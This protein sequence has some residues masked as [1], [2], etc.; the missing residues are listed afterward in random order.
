VAAIEPTPPF[1]Y[2]H[3][4]M[5]ALTDGDDRKAKT[6]FEREVACA[7]DNDEFH[8]WLAIACLRL[9]EKTE[10]RQQL[11]L[12]L[13]TSTTEERRGL[14]SSKLAQLMSARALLNQAPA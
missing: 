2:F 14:Y 10:A 12:A 5:A 7:P 9:G 11:A 13:D 3:L 8:F 6:L 4:G 1:H